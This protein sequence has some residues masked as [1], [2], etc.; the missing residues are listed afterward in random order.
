MNK[1]M[2]VIGCVKSEFYRRF[3]APYEDGK[4]RPKNGD[5]DPY[6][7]KDDDD[8]DWLSQISEADWGDIALQVG[9]KTP[10]PRRIESEEDPGGQGC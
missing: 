10:S 7:W 2:G 3:V 5:I 1:I 9:V 4:A 6:W 8:S